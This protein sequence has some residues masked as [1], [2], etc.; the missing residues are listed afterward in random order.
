MCC[1]VQCDGIDPAN[2]L[3]SFWNDLSS[4]HTR[5]IKPEPMGKNLTR[6][7]SCR[8][9]TIWVESGP[10]KMI[11][12]LHLIANMKVENS[13]TEKNF[14]WREI[15]RGYFFYYYY[16]AALCR[17]TTSPASLMAAGG[18]FNA[19]KWKRKSIE[20]TKSTRKPIL[21]NWNEKHV[22]TRVP[23]PVGFARLS[24]EDHPLLDTNAIHCMWGTFHWF[25]FCLPYNSTVLHFSD[26]TFWMENFLLGSWIVDRGRRALP[27]KCQFSLLTIISPVR[28][29]RTV[30]TNV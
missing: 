10:L 6:K 16:S 24:T 15:F 21:C 27:R 3:G 23:T 4:R 22:V 18:D 7:C 29:K 17:A 25:I 14:I 9:S 2:V 19:F 11:L 13:W 26:W 1:P 12:P 28:V 20:N 5:Q 8:L 30:N